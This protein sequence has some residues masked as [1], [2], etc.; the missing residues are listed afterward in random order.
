MLVIRLRRAGANRRPFFRIVVAEARSPREGRFVETL[1]HYDPR[2]DPP[3]VTIDRA[4]YEY[5]IG[6]GAQP[7]ATVRTLVA[8]TP[9]DVPAA[10]GRP[11]EP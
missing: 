1:G 7:S 5:W 3:A 4:R 2:S 9:A 6:R 8:R 11:A 10:A